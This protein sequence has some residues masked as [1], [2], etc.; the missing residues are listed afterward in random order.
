MFAGAISWTRTA[1]CASACFRPAAR[2]AS[3]ALRLYSDAHTSWT[4]EPSS[5]DDDVDTP[6]TDSYRPA[7]DI[8]ARSSTLALDLTTTHELVGIAAAICAARSAGKGTH[9]IRSL[10]ALHASSIAAG[11]GS[12]GAV[13]ASSAAMR[14]V[15]SSPLPA[16]LMHVSMTPNGTN[17]P[18]GALKPASGRSAKWVS[19]PHTE[20]LVPP[21][22]LV[23]SP[24]GPHS[25]LFENCTVPCA[26]TF[27]SGALVVGASFPFFPL[28]L[29]LSFLPLALSFLPL[30]F[31]LTSSSG[32]GTGS[33]AAAAGA[34]AG[35]A[36]GSDAG[37]L[38]AAPASYSAICASDAGAR[39]TPSGV[40]WK[41][42]H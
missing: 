32:S 20:A 21:V 28:P 4:A 25:S 12:W 18:G 29:P 2:R 14:L 15:S 37:L 10:T 39:I 3:T 31:F 9:S 11:S 26:V 24:S 5:A 27:V 13:A 41:N 19:S 23:A 6:S 40:T 34:G 1:M 16:S 7:A 35:A 22:S 8:P 42:T 30:P 17:T 33:G 38:R 36:G